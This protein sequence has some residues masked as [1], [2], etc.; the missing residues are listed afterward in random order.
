MGPS[1]IRAETRLVS[2]Q[3]NRNF[4]PSAEGHASVTAQGGHHGDLVGQ[5]TATTT[6]RLP[7]AATLGASH[8]EKVGRCRHESPLAADRELPSMPATAADACS[9]LPALPPTAAPPMRAPLSGALAARWRPCRPGR[10]QARGAAA[11]QARHWR[12]HDASGGAGTLPRWWPNKVR[13]WAGP[14]AARAGRG[15]F[16][17]GAV[18]AIPPR[19]V[20][21]PTQGAQ[22]GPPPS[23]LLYRKKKSHVAQRLAAGKAP[24]RQDLHQWQIFRSAGERCARQRVPSAACGAGRL[25]A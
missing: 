1:V 18:A 19:P 10:A 25:A 17:S 12:G 16:G 9:E 15:S 14:T 22:T 6:A 3:E 8:G 7:P 4:L 20:A 24:V 21:L 11:I 23:R 5:K 13:A 2:W